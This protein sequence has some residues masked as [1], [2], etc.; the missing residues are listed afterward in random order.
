[1]DTL[2]FFIQ[3]LLDFWGESMDWLLGLGPDQFVRVFWAF[4]FLEIPR[5]FFTDLYVLFRALHSRDAEPAGEQ[6]DSHA[7]VSVV[8]PALNEEDTIAYTVRSLLD[9]HYPNIEIVVVD[10]G[11]TDRT[12]EVCQKLAEQG[13][14]RYFRL[15]SRQGKSAA[16]N[17]GVKAARGDIIIFMDTD[18]TLDRNV[19]VTLLNYFRDERVG[20][21][22]GNLGV[23]NAHVNILTALQAIEYLV[24]I[25]VGRWFRASTGILAIVPGAFGAFRRELVERVG[26]HEPGPGN[27][28]DL[29]IRTRKLKKT[30]AFAPDATCLTNVPERW[31]SW[32]KQRMRWDR[33]VIKNRVRKHRDIYNFYDA[34]FSLSNLLSFVD[35][36]FFGV[37]LTLIW[38]VYIIDTIINYPDMYRLILFANLCL[39]A[40]L[41]FMQFGIVLIISERRREHLSLIPYLPFYVVY[42]LLLKLV[43]L[44]ASLQELLFRWSYRDPFAPVKVRGQMVRW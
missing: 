37:L 43:R 9:Q 23:R 19:I 24:S 29:T 33:N 38:V 13:L 30:I 26:G 27:D 5:Y 41:K 18:S 39:H 36:V 3:G 34:N 22:S 21:V 14:I 16:L 31:R 10:D 15:T 20:A 42:R 11:S 32:L 17:Y 2:A 35:T 28:S 8:L 25:T 7:P 12:P 6:L 1:M 40:L 4:L 44:T